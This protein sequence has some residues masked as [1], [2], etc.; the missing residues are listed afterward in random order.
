MLLA[1]SIVSY[2]MENDFK[3]SL[4]EKGEDATALLKLGLGIYNKMTNNLE[5]PQEKKEEIIGLNAHGVGFLQAMVWAGNKDWGLI[6]IQEKGEDV[7]FCG[8]EKVTQPPNAIALHMIPIA[9]EQAEA[10]MK[11][12]S[13]LIQ[14]ISAKLKPDSLVSARPKGVTNSPINKMGQELGFKPCDDYPINRQFLW[15][16]EWQTLKKVV[17][18]KEDTK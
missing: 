5:I 7:G 13:A 2:A 8:I 18:Q 11:V 3:F 4:V 14:F 17:E 6:R 16:G 15:N 10:R 9:K 12:A 1:C